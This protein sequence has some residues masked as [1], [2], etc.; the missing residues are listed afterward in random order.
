IRFGP[1]PDCI[2]RVDPHSG[3]PL[4][5]D[6]TAISSLVQP[7]DP[8]HEVKRAAVIQAIVGVFDVQPTDTIHIPLGVGRH[9]DHQ[10]VRDLGKA[11]IRW[12]PIN[13]VLFYE[14]FPYTR[15][16]EAA[17]Q[18]AVKTLDLEVARVTHPLDADAIDARIA[19][20]KCYKSQLASLKW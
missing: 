9:V 18:S 10:I 8:L 19:A 16:G 1:Y 15:Q 3:A 7:T 5:P 4:Y 13:P 17:I 20:I 11:L 12:R 14:D 6:E 2:Y